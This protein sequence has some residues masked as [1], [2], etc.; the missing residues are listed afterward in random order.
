MFLFVLGKLLIGD[1]PRLID[2]WQ[3]APKLWDA[4]RYEVDSRGDVGQFM[5]TGSAVPPNMEE[6]FFLIMT[7]S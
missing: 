7:F 5:L 3:I 6:K 4:V 1:T 2:E